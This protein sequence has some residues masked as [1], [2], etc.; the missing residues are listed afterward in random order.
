MQDKT[1]L[2]KEVDPLESQG[3]RGK[4][5]LIDDAPEILALYGNVLRHERF[6]VRLASSPREAF[7]TL[8][9]FE[10]DLVVLD[11]M[12]PQMS[13]EQVLREL[14]KRPN[15]ADTPVVFL[16]AM[17][18][19]E[20]TI[21]AVLELGANDFLTKPLDRRLLVAK[22]AALVDGRRRANLSRAYDELAA[23]QRALLANLEEARKVQNAYL[24]PTQ[25]RFGPVDFRAV[26]EP[27]EHVGGD[28]Y[29]VIET[30]C[31]TI[32]VLVDVSG[33]GLAAALVSASVRSTLR[34]LLHTKSL[35]D[36]LRELNRQLCVDNDDHYVCIAMV[37]CDG[38]LM[39]VVNAGLPP[40]VRLHRGEVEAR[41]L[42]TGIPPGLVADAEYEEVVWRVEPGMDV[43]M[44]SDGFAELF[45]DV[46][47]VDHWAPALDLLPADNAR[48]QRSLDRCLQDA[49]HG[50]G[51][52]LRDDSTVVVLSIAEPTKPTLHSV[53]TP[54]RD[55]DVA[56]VRFSIP[57][58]VEVIPRALSIAAR[59][60]GR[61]PEDPAVRA[62]L[63][64]ALLNAVVHGSLGVHAPPRDR[65]LGGFLAEVRRAE[66]NVPPD[67]TVAVSVTVAEDGYEVAITD[68]GDGFRWQDL[69]QGSGPPD[70]LLEG[71]R[72]IAI[73][74]AGTEDV[75]WNEKGNQVKLRF[76]R[77]SKE[78]D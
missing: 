23:A 51:G 20:H 21:G 24:P 78:S 9:S 2:G 74:R 56:D 68:Q 47:G 25:G 6:E 34:L 50:S 8:E 66:Q 26:L 10:P 37:L 16:T 35:P 5:L 11:Y 14:R 64:E 31:G 30:T 70:P 12:M 71:G 58:H 55:L 77:P 62:P 15:F 46:E 45:D 27:C 3:V 75:S 4:V 53:D 54:P 73:M 17:S 63:W 60:M 65:E 69:P 18:Q 57:P 39:R 36:A 1:Q 61:D 43:V 72:G 76:P 38:M 67:K 32:T 59:A 29:D 7:A 13:G 28:L 40:I 33:H 22:V 49:I 44:V 42:A 41:V 52:K 48:S 19:D